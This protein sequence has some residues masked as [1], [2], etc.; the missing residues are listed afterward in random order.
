MKKR[1]LNIV[2]SI[3]HEIDLRPRVVKSKKNYCRK[4]KHKKRF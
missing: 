3:S 4:E 2:L 1:D